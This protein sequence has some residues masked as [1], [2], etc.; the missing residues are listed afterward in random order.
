MYN[1]QS[2]TMARIILHKNFKNS[3]QCFSLSIFN[4]AVVHHLGFL[5]LRAGRRRRRLYVFGLSVRA[6]VRPCVHASVRP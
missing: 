2:K 1:C 3:L 4:M 5:S 6:A